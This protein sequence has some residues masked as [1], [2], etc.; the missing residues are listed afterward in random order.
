MVNKHRGEIA[1]TL[2]GRQWTLCLTALMIER[3]LGIR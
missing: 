2:D 1:A 3:R